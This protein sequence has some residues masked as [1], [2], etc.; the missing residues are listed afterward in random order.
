MIF[1]SVCMCFGQ[2][3]WKLS[4]N[5]GIF[6]LLLGLATYGIGGLTTILAYRHGK[7]SILQPMLSISYVVSLFLAS[8]VLGEDIRTIDI[9]GVCLIVLGAFFVAGGDHE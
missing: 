3:F 1:A 5:Q 8:G 6:F 4:V 9:L 7:L 2:L